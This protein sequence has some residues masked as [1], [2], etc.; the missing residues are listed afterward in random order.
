MNTEPRLHD[1]AANP[2][3]RTP[4]PEPR[5][6][7]YIGLFLVALS[8]LMYEILLTRIFSVTIWYHFAYLTI[9]TA[10]LGFGAAGS[11]L[12]AKPSLLDRLRR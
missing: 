8:T 7:T 5:T 11:L 10:L 1:P 9:S 3:P 12:V 6:A 2:H 4:N